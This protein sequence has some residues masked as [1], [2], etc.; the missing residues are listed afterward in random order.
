[1]QLVL[2]PVVN[3]CTRVL[4]EGMVLRASDIDLGSVLGYS[5]PPYRYRLNDSTQSYIYSL[6]R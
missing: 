5:F 1:M 4:E 2:L 6:T 3:E